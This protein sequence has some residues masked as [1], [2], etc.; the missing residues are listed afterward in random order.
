MRKGSG[1][2]SERTDWRVGY[3]DSHSRLHFGHKLFVS[4]RIVLECNG[5]FFPFAVF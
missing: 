3:K 4:V 5:L 2:N 1:L